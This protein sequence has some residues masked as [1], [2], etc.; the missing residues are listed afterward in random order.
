MIKSQGLQG[1]TELKWDMG[2]GDIITGL[3]PVPYLYDKS[4]TY[5]ITL[6]I[7]NRGCTKTMSKTIIFESLFT[8]NV[9]TPNNDGKNDKFTIDN[10]NEN[11]N[12]V[13]ANRYG[14][15]VFESQN[16]NND[17]EVYYSNSL[18]FYTLTTPLGKQCSGWIQVLVR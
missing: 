10:P 16:Y 17:W 11:W 14:Q 1:F 12:L 8:T 18:Y 9:I 7:N 6:T 15:I 3:S 2:N 5:T 13:I 4:G